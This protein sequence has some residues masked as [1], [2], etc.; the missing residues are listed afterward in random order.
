MFREFWNIFVFKNVLKNIN[1]ESYLTLPLTLIRFFF[2]FI[3]QNKIYKPSQK[4]TYLRIFK[5]KIVKI[6]VFLFIPS[7]SKT[8]RDRGKIPTEIFLE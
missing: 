8:K 4:I 7:V 5:G 6:G 3:V 2:I 1:K